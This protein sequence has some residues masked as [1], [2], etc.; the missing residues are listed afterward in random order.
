MKL[1]RKQIAVILALISSLALGLAKLLEVT[2]D[3]AETIHDVVS[4]VEVPAD[5]GV[6]DAGK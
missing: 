5:A 1:N 2:P 3:S 4:G 6:A